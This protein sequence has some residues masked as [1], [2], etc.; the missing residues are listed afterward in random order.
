MPRA[1]AGWLPRSARAME[2]DVSEERQ[3][4]PST[5]LSKAYDH[6]DVEPRWYRTWLE[7]GYFHAD[8]NDRTRPAFSIV[9]P[10]PNVTGSLHMG[11][12]LTATIQ[13]ILIRWKRMAGFNALWLP[14]TDHAGIATQM[15]VEKEL[16]RTEKKSRH[17]LGREEFLR[18]VWEWKEQYGG[19]ISEQHKVLGRLARLAARALHHGRGALPGRA[20]GVRAALRGGAH[21][22]GQ[23][24]HQLVPALPHRAL[25]PR[26]EPRGEPAGELWS[27]AY[28]LAD[29]SGEIVVATT[30][31]ETMLGDTAVAVHPED[32]RCAAWSAGTS[33]SRSPAASSRSSPTPCSSTRSS[34][35]A[36]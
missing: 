8:E 7:R 36:R 9:I 3:T 14:G 10:P 25:R 13:D 6:R 33:A 12:A 11:H 30:R 18:R 22:P 34:A 4:P 5:E 1:G 15:V 20:R 16:Q 32:E 35:P 31:P 24:A 2:S 28:P 23:A 19:R 29:G 26:G 21:L 27:I 17:D